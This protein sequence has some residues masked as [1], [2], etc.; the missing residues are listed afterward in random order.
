MKAFFRIPLLFL[1]IGGSI[2][3][4]L[5][6][7]F[8]SPLP[9]LR[10]GNWLHAHSHMMFLGWITNFLFLAFIYVWQKD[11]WTET[12]RAIFLVMQVLVAGML[13][14]FPAQGY[15]TV[16]VI[17]LALHN[18]CC[19]ILCFRFYRQTRSMEGI[20]L[21]FIRSALLFFVISSVGAFALGPISANGLGQSMWYYFAIFLY[22]HFQYNGFFIF[23]ILGLFVRQLQK[24]EIQIDSVR[25]KKSHRLLFYS[26]FPAYLLSVL[27]SGPSNTIVA[28]AAASAIVQVIALVLFLIAIRPAFE[29]IRRQY[30]V[31]SKVLLGASV[32][33]FVIKTVLQLLSSAPFIADL[34]SDVR[35]FVLAYL[36]LVLIGMISFYAIAWLIEE[37]LIRPYKNWLLF[38]FLTSFIASELIMIAVP[39]FGS[40]FSVFTL[41]LFILAALMLA[42][43]A[44]PL[45]SL[46][47]HH[48]PEE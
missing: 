44:K 26:C 36:H 27:W 1:V 14:S 32:L 29:E 34:A 11:K 28:I 43:F 13:V 38:T 20:A 31:S 5:R 40:L 41:W 2:G 9:F 48:A 6:Y 45:F 12:Y 37:K 35:F 25:I 19:Y 7:H 47:S 8:V 15:G 10:F 16:S 3:L 18:V 22:L 30:S 17:L 23:G 39:I 4:L 21:P 24:N 46:T 42:G 33:S